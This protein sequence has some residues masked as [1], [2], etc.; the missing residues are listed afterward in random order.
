MYFLLVVFLIAGTGLVFYAQGWR[1]NWKTLT[2]TR[3]GGIY[4]RSFPAEAQITLDG[5]E[6]KNRSGLIQTGTFIGNLFP[7]SYR[8]TLAMP[9]FKTIER[10][11]VVKPSLV[12]ELNNLVLVPIGAKIAAT[13]TDNF[14]PSTD[15]SPLL[16]KLKL[17]TASAKTFPDPESSNQII[18]QSPLLISII[19]I[20]RSQSVPL[21]SFSATS[22]AQIAAAAADRSW[23]VW[24]TYNK[25]ERTSGITAYERLFRTRKTLP[26]AIPGKTVKMERASGSILGF[27][28]DN[29]EFYL[30]QPAKNELIHLAS[31]V[32]DFAFSPD[33]DKVAV[34]GSRGL[35]IFSLDNKN[36][37]RF[38]L[39]EAQKI[40]GFLWYK[41]GEH[42]FVSYP[43][44]TNF[45]DLSDA[46][47]QSF[48]E[49]APTGNVRYDPQEN[50]LYYLQDKNIFALE[51]PS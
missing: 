3:V 43:N 15:F 47:L 1:L 41:D 38:N 49:A 26:Q 19:D 29:G 30:Y 14:W 7:K 44:K 25:K 28:Q 11:V 24:S 8:L 2:P 23:I 46:G 5:K 10:N 17:K 31:D 9:D 51:F 12:T 22:T 37:W 13:S 40:S 16:K 45:L 18:Y 48:L 34:L 50:I 21:E 32:R 20:Q 39:A 42:I 4:I 6:I 33:A 36:Y 27:N 35:E